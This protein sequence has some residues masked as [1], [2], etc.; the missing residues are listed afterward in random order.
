METSR[1]HRH[2]IRKLLLTHNCVESCYCYLIEGSLG[3][4]ALPKDVSLGDHILNT[5]LALLTFIEIPTTALVHPAKK[6]TGLRE[7]RVR[8]HLGKKGKRQTVGRGALALFSLAHSLILHFHF[9][10]FLCDSRSLRT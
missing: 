5:L 10:F 6:G 9:F 8:I 4:P 3:L 1:Y 2:K 7:T